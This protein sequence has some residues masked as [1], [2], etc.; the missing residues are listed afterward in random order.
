MERKL[1]VWE[2]FTR[3]IYWV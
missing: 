1:F 2:I 3:L